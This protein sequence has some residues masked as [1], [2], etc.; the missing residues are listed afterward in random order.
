M[1]AGPATGSEDH[2]YLPSLG[3]SGR[4]PADL[5]L[6]ADLAALDRAVASALPA[7]ASADDVS[8]WVAAAEALRSI[9]ITGQSERRGQSRA[10]QEAVALKLGQSNRSSWMALLNH[11]AAL[12]GAVVAFVLT[13]MVIR[14][15]PR[16]SL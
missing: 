10:S 12:A 16:G 1:A 8:G 7:E 13:Y 4:V 15:M 2:G 14:V 5:G 11:L 3:A 9:A 6:L